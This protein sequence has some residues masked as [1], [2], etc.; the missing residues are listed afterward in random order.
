MEWREVPFYGGKYEASTEGRV[1]NTVSGKEVVPYQINPEDE[2][3]TVTL[4]HNGKSR[5]IGLHRVIA[6]TFV[7]NYG[8]QTVVHHKD[9][10]PKNNRPDNLEWVS[11]Q[12]NTALGNGK[13]NAY[14]VKVYRRGS[15]VVKRYQTR[16]EFLK[17]FKA[18]GDVKT[19]WRNLLPY[20]S[21]GK[22]RVYGLS[23]VTFNW[24]ISG[25]YEGVIKE[26]I[27]RVKAINGANSAGKGRVQ[28]WVGSL[29]E[30]ELAKVT[31]DVQ[32][33][34]QRKFKEAYGKTQVTVKKALGL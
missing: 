25:G 15:E 29:N 24:L 14:T 27:A 8:M 9:F 16:T 11:T 12:Y 7:P 17:E 33:M 1:R 31:E 2:H 28:V 23:E 18:T 10:N 30:I 21:A 26:R 19:L 3:L 34:S 4:T 13:H 20:M 22:G 6:T 32:T 5:A